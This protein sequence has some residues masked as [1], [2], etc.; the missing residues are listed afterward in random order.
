[1]EYP[2]RFTFSITAGPKPASLKCSMAAGTESPL[3]STGIFS[4]L[5]KLMPL[6]VRWNK[7]LKY[8]IAFNNQ[9]ILISPF[10]IFGRCSSPLITLGSTVTSTNKNC[11][12]DLNIL[13]VETVSAVGEVVVPRRSAISR[14]DK[15]E[16]SFQ[17]NK[18]Q[19]R[20]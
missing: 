4:Y 2:L 1:M 14:F 9:N 10:G 5:S 12:S 8:H 19:Q 20:K 3:T 16:A 7:L 11:N 15:R 17:V 13:V 6:S 18:K